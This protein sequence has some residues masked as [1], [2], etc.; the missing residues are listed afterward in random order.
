MQN[1]LRTDVAIEPTA[2]HGVIG[3]LSPSIRAEQQMADDLPEYSQAQSA[4]PERSQRACPGHS[5]RFLCK[6]KDVAVEEEQLCCEHIRNSEPLDG[7]ANTVHSCRADQHKS[8]GSGQ[9]EAYQDRPERHP[10]CRHG[11]AAD[12]AD[13]HPV[14]QRVEDADE[15][16]EGS[17]DKKTREDISERDIPFAGQRDG[18]DRKREQWQ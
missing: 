1:A 5:Q 9:Q 13:Y 8:G 15:H 2:Q 12:L 16:R 10:A 17:D 14:Q 7:H 4:L 11:H 18:K 6:H 3:T